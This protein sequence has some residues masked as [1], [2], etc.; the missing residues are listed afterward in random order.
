MSVQEKMGYVGSLC[1]DK[2]EQKSEDDPEND[3]W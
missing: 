3:W 1:M 2:T